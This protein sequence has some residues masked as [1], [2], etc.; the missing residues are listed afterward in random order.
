[1]FRDDSHLRVED[2]CVPCSAHRTYPVQSVCYPLHVVTAPHLYR[3][4]DD[5][6]IVT[7]V[8]SGINGNPCRLVVSC[9]QNRLSGSP[10]ISESLE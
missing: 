3:A 8:A 9:A 6:D 2:R 1:M 4:I 7:L 10:M 5:E